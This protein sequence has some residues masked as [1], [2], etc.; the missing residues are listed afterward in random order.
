MILRH[1]IYIYIYMLYRMRSMKHDREDKTH[2]DFY[3]YPSLRQNIAEVRHTTSFYPAKEKCGHKCT[4]SYLSISLCI[5]LCLLCMRHNNTNLSIFPYTLLL[6]RF[7][8]LHVIPK[9]GTKN[10]RRINLRNLL[11][12]KKSIMDIWS[13]WAGSLLILFQA[14]NVIVQPYNIDSSSSHYHH[15]HYYYYYPF[16]LY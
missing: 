9:E 16:R 2:K 13:S 10:P 6:S 3:R 4:F 12:K 8:S 7:S 15:H 11:H 1:Y 5:H 14:G